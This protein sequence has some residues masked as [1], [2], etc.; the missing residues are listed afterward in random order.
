[1]IAVTGATGHLGK[2]I[3]E[4]ALARTPAGGVA[5][6]CR[7]PSKAAG[8]AARGVQVRRGDFADPDA[9]SDAFAGVDRV[10]IV[11]PD[12]LGEEGLRLSR[13]AVAAARSAGVRRVLYTSQVGTH[14]GSPFAD[15]VHVEQTLAE[16]GLPWTSLRNGF[17]VESLL[18]LI[19][20]GL[21][22]GEIAVPED[23]PVSWTARAD[24]AE[25]NAI[26]LADDGRYDGLTPPLTAGE[27]VTM[28]DVAEMASELT[29]REI[30]LIR[31]SD[32]QWRDARVAAG[33]PRPM[34]EMLASIFAAMRQGDFAAVDPA[35]EGLLGRKPTSVR[36]VLSDHLARP[37]PH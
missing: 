18:Q 21:T 27:A 26:I 19:G 29:G 1:M 8:L 25:A 34:A 32:A 23:G 15:H 16:G 9:L 17:Y 11:S 24:L 2:L 3:L 31:V 6:T 28:K 14:A 37:E 4:H 35:L 7:D 30:R 5:A 36:D 13:N 10:L 20:D 12:K 33:V 22:T